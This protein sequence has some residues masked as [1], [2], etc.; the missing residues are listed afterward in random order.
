MV[1]LMMFVL[2]A[3]TAITF[4]GIMIVLELGD[5]R[6]GRLPVNSRASVPLDGER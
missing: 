6:K 3:A 5:C 2:A 4:E 1:M